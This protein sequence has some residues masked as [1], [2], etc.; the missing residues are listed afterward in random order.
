MLNIVLISFVL[1]FIGARLYSIYIVRSVFFNG[2]HIHHFYFGMVF[3]SIGGVLGILS[4]KNRYLELA[5]IFV[6]GGIGLFADEIGLLLN[7]TTMTREC[8]YAFPRISDI[9]MIIAALIILVIIST[10]LIERHIRNKKEQ[11]PPLDS[12]LE[13]HEKDVTD[14]EDS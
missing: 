11:I 6:G 1:F 10:G 2:Y 8:T 4:Q 9:V 13:K 14:E 7:C 5:S 3:L 12:S